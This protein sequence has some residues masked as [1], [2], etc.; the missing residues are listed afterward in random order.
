MQRRLG[1]V[2]MLGWGSLGIILCCSVGL[3]V[4]LCLRIGVCLFLIMCV[5]LSMGLGFM[6]GRLGF[7]SVI[8]EYCFKMI[9]QV[10]CSQRFWVFL[11]LFIFFLQGFPKLFR[12][13]FGQIADVFTLLEFKFLFCLSFDTVVF[14][15]RWNKSLPVFYILFSQKYIS[16]LF[17]IL[18]CVRAFC[19]KPF[20]VIVYILVYWL[21]DTNY[22]NVT[23]YRGEQWTFRS[24]QC[25]LRK[26]NIKTD[27][28]PS[29]ANQIP[30]ST[31]FFDVTKYL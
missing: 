21:H 16:G 22:D 11:L 26:A 8:S 9:Q 30:T 25:P 23:F 10:V 12:L 17:E 3:S 31:E 6:M 2:F 29:P 20:D 18:F 27:K 19:I 24:M 14:R 7:A 13:F 4:R 1:S 15:S 5:S 28:Q